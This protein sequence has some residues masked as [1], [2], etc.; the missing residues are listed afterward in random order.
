[1]GQTCTVLLGID[2][3]VIACRDPD[4]AAAQLTGLAGLEAL[5]GGRHPRWGTFNRL[6]W[7][8]DSYLELMGVEDPVLALGR[9]IGAATQRLLAAGREGVASFSLASD[10][11]A[12]DVARL[13][14]AGSRYEDPAPGERR[15][16]DGEVVR[17]HTALPPAL[18]PDRPP[19]LVQHDETAA[20]WR[21]AERADRAQRVHP[22]GGTAT[23]ARL[24]IE[25]DDP[26]AAGTS[27]TEAL[28]LVPVAVDDG[29][30]DFAIGSHVVRLR[31][32]SGLPD[33]TVVILGIEGGP[34]SVDLLGCRIQ[35]EIASRG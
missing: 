5:P 30:V 12:G 7:L 14:A 17:W 1:M 15:R 18:G 32:R 4:H 2:H 25:V 13:R 22:F 29:S 20:E 26:L 27:Y 31:P 24:E 33:A 6:V 3:I 8:G 19:F 10:D 21:P 28:G 9:E 11:L 35:V 23:L 34:R 16:P